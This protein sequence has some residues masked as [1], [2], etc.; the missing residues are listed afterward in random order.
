MNKSG[1]VG[2]DDTVKWIGY[3]GLLAAAS[4]AVWKMID[5]IIG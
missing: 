3:L 5:R 2:V 1:E 4:F